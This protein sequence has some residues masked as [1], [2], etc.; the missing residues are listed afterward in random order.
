MKPITARRTRVTSK[1]KSGL[2]TFLKN[3]KSDGK[4]IKMSFLARRGNKK[5]RVNFYVKEK[6]HKNCVSKKKMIIEIKKIFKKWKRKAYYV[7][8]ELA[9]IQKELEKE[10]E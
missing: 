3:K 10:V 8:I 1:T 6:G 7:N 4:K 9:E 5:R 2:N